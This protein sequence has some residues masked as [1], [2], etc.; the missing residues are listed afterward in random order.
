MMNKKIVEIEER[1]HRE[2]CKLPREVQSRFENLFEILEEQGKLE[3]PYAKKIKRKIFEIRINFRGQWRGLYS[4][5][6]NRI[7]LLSFFKKKST[8]T[9]MSEILKTT[10]R[11]NELKINEKNLL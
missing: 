8:K 7:V 6:G 11:L 5:L 10:K 1:A 3:T 4:Y 9:P 2:F